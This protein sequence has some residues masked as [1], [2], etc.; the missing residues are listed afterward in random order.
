MLTDR[1]TG[2]GRDPRSVHNG[3]EKGAVALDDK[4]IMATAFFSM[5]GSCFAVVAYL[6]KL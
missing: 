6:A 2:P 1:L 3:N 4:S 5:A